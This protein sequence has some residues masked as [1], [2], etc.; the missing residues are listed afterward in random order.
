MFSF[1][2]GRSGAQIRRLNSGAARLRLTVAGSVACAAALWSAGVAEAGKKP[3]CFGKEATIVSNANRVT[4]T[5]RDDVIVAGRGSQ[6]IDGG[7]GRDLICADGGNDRVD[8]GA[9]RDR[10]DG[11]TGDDRLD[12]GPE[13]DL[14]T[15][16][17][18]DDVIKGDAN[19]GDTEDVL[20]GG[21]GDDLIQGGDGRDVMFDG[22][23]ADVL[24]GDGADDWI[25]PQDDRTAD[26]YSGGP[27]IDGINYAADEDSKYGDGVAVS[28]DGVANDGVNCPQQCEGDNAGS[29]I[30]NIH[31]SRGSDTLVG[32]AGPNVIE[33][34][35]YGYGTTN[36]MDGLGGADILRGGSASDAIAGGDGD[37]RLQGGPGDDSVDGGNDTDACF[38][39][40]GT[41]VAAACETE[42]GFP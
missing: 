15:G 33:D 20:T 21:S 29:D 10:I 31:G 37:D 2:L 34:A 18:G 8:G 16:N 11:D 39:D 42:I 23:G 36:T 24:R 5:A 12:G 26:R 7:G 40:E 3:E 19:S 30:E 38:G 1:T 14:V 41:D 27:G 17:R 13:A 9:G 6:R 22:P 28:L 4:G 35:A 25:V 32:N